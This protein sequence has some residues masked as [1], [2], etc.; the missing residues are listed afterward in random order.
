MGYEVKVIADNMA[1]SGVRLT[2]LQCTYPRIVHSEMMTHRDFSRNSASSRAIPVEKM[3]ERV[4]T[5]PFIPIY[6]GKNQK[7][8]QAIEEL[9]E[10]EQK[11]AVALW[12]VARDNAVN[13]VCDM[14]EKRVHKQIVNRLLEPFLWHTVIISATRWSNFFAQRCHP[15]AQ[16]EIQRAAYMMRDAMQESVPAYISSGAWHLPYIQPDDCSLTPKE[17]RMVSVARCARV[18][19][20]SQ[21]G[22]RD[23]IADFDLYERLESGMHFSPFEHVAQASCDPDYR[24]G[25]FHGWRQMRKGIAN[26]CR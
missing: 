24:S 13:S 9:S 22:V 16:P 8:M 11:D 19:Y 1:P 20:L 7:G 25:N 12:L 21:E 3:I 14:L 17:L 6:W 23:H 2:T 26:E 18:S 15:D 10:E 5:D 4:L